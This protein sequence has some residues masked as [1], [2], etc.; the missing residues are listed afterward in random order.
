M[1]DIVEKAD[2]CAQ[3]VNRMMMNE[4]SRET[5]L[6]FIRYAYM[7]GANEQLLDDL[8]SVIRADDELQERT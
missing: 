2:R 8:A 1:K 7:C 3:S 4:P 5:I 6:N